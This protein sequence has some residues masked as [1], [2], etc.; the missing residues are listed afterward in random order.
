MK[1]V[2]GSLF[3]VL[4]ILGLFANAVVQSPAPWSAAHDQFSHTDERLLELHIPGGRYLS[5]H[6]YQRCEKDGR[7]VQYHADGRTTWV[8]G[9]TCWDWRRWVGREMSP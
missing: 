9:I 8:S 6:T 4:I 3:A 2:L 1:Y 5:K 7:I